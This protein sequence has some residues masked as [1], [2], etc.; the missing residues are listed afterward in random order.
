MT[1]AK[2]LWMA[3]PRG[4]T[5]I[6]K[7]GSWEKSPFLALPKGSFVLLA[8]S[9]PNNDVIVVSTGV[10]AVAKNWRLYCERVK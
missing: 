2:S 5:F 10:F 3:I 1:V 9:L 4:D 8:E 6:R 7:T